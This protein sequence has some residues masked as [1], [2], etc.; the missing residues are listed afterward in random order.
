MPFNICKLDS[1]MDLLVETH[2]NLMLRCHQAH[3][4]YPQVPGIVR[5]VLNHM[6]DPTQTRYV[7][8][9]PVT[10][11][12]LQS[13]LHILDDSNT[14]GWNQTKHE[15][16][17]NGLGV[18]AAN[19]YTRSWGLLHQ[20]TILTPPHH[21]GIGL[22]AWITMVTGVKMWVTFNP[23]AKHD[24]ASRETMLQLALDATF[25]DNDKQT[26]LRKEW[27]LN[28]KRKGLAYNQ[29]DL[30]HSNTM[31]ASGVPFIAGGSGA[32]T[33]RRTNKRPKTNSHQSENEYDP[34]DPEKCVG[35][36][37][38]KV[39]GALSRSRPVPRTIEVVD[40]SDN[41]AENF[42]L[43]TI[44]LYPGDVYFQLPGA[45]HAVYTPV[46]SF[47]YGGH[48]YLYD[49]MHLTELSR[50]VDAMHLSYL[51]N[52]EHGHA[53]EMLVRMVLALPRLNPKREQGT[54]GVQLEKF[55][56]IFT[57]I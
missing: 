16:P 32:G 39:P 8:D 4:S 40:N 23:S 27:A 24:R 21:D 7:L 19:L 3:Y 1:Q 36:P 20:P 51:T 42:D 41:F 57:F 53:E 33:L 30:K 14:I 5:D 12:G 35:A 46:G 43:E 26:R 54:I 49:T 56:L 37:P 11:E 17:A 52:T 29:E 44:T 18:H 34:N 10:L 15:Y 55:S 25:Y 48:Y 50:D 2:I 28:N 13:P 31:Q 38:L 45:F 47:A 6:D 9:L 22:G